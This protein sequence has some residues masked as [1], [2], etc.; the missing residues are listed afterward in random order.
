MSSNRHAETVREIAEQQ[1]GFGNIAAAEALVIAAAEIDRLAGIERG[2][3]AASALHRAEGRAEAVARMT[4]ALSAPEVRGIPARL[5]AAAEML[6]K[7]PDMEGTAI[8]EFVVAHIMQPKETSDDYAA[9][10]AASMGIVA[11][12]VRPRG[13]V[14]APTEEAADGGV[15]VNADAPAEEFSEVLTS[16]TPRDAG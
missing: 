15:A 9:R 11:A 5:A 16:D 8:A 4:A 6:V 7:A 12:P 10:R 1:Q 14:A 3:A 13:P 2:G